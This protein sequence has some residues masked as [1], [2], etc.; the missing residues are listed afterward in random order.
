MIIGRGFLVSSAISSKHGY[1]FN[2]QYWQVLPQHKKLQALGCIIV[3]DIRAQ[4]RY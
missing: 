3:T 2:V 4:S 1:V